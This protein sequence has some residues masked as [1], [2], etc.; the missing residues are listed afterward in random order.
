MGFRLVDGETEDLGPD[1]GWAMGPGKVV[2]GDGV[3]CLC[4]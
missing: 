3:C 1:T 2:E 4:L